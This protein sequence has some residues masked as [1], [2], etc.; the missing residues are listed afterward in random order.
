M[1]RRIALKAAYAALALAVIAGVGAASATPAAARVIVGFGIA[2]FGYYP[3]PWGYPY[4]AYPY[5]P[6]AYPAPYYAP[7]YG[8]PVAAPASSAAPE[9]Q[10]TWY[11]CDNPSGYYPY[12]Q[13]CSVGWRQVPAQPQP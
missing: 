6:P 4:Y 2:P 12:V 7:A 3:G 11:Y 5:Y 10:G 1:V 13:Q 8:P 9:Q